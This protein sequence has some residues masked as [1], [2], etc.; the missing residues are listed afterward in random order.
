MAD[1]LLA[2]AVSF[3]TWARANDVPNRVVLT[4]TGVAW[5]IALFWWSRRK[6]NSVKRCVAKV[7]G[8]KS[9]FTTRMA[10]PMM[11]TRF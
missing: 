10:A 7:R 5:P 4:F 6:V 3:W 1:S 8:S 9:S 11:D 2:C